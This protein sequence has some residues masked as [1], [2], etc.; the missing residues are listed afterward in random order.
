V[1]K[2]IIFDLYET[3]I[4][5]FDPNW[6]PPKLTMAERIGISEEHYQKH[7]S[8]LDDSWQ[9]GQLE[10]YEE[11]LLELCRTAA[12]TPSESVIAELVLEH[13][14]TT[15]IPF[16]NIEP[17][18]VE[19][20]QE[21][22]LWGFRLGIITNASDMDVEMWPDCRLAPL[23]DVFIPSFQ[24]GILKPDPQIFELGLRALGVN[25]SEAIFVGD[26]GYD[27]LAGATQV[28]LRA[29]WATWFLDRWPFGIRPTRFDCDEWR[30]FPEGEP[31]FPRLRTPRE[32]L[33]LVS[34]LWILR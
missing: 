33:D 2:A 22:G 19:L 30:Q 34:S 29:F 12:H 1:F 24:V 14:R 31:P 10:S 20:V 28:G 6:K 8:R 4:T 13:S 18:I 11:L 5:H 27:E 9:M 26:G 32:L 17:A 7:W 25:A 15:R 3:L 23:F 21:L 16:Q